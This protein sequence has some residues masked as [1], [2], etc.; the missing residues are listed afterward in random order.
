MQCKIFC[1]FFCKKSSNDPVRREEL[2]AFCHDQSIRWAAK[3]ISSTLSGFV[4][5]LKIST[6]PPTN[7]IRLRQLSSS[8]RS[9]VWKESE[10]IMRTVVHP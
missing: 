7:T 8:P 9:T 3:A 2:S 6:M 10:G 5:G 4:L 1:E